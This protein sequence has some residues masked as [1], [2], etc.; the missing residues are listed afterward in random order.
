MRMIKFCQ[1]IMAFVLI[2]SL[3]SIVVSCSNDDNPTSISKD[4]GMSDPD[5][6]L[7]V[8]GVI[9][10]VEN[11]NDRAEL[12]VTYIA[13]NGLYMPDLITIKPVVDGDIIDKKSKYFWIGI[14]TYTV[15]AGGLSQKV[16]VRQEGE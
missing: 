2:C 4:D 14:G 6:E 7:A 10:E 9:F 1:I 8:N 16:E 13:P 3:N 12:I 11:E 15:T 5:G